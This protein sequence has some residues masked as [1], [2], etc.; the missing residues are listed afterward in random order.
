MKVDVVDRINYIR[1]ES[2]N[3]NTPKITKTRVVEKVANLN[4]KFSN[5]I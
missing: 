3:T 4:G 1:L 2:I 5:E